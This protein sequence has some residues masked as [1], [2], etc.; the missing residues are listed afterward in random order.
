[1]VVS[2]RGKGELGRDQA[3][4]WFFILSFSVLFDLAIM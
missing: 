2:G 3:G 1:M 4:N